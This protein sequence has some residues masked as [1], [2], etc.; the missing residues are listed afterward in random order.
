MK[1]S[2]SFISFFK[3][4]SHAI[5]MPT[6]FFFITNLFISGNWGIV[7]SGIWIFVATVTYHFIDGVDKDSKKVFFTTLGLEAALVL[8]FT[9][10]VLANTL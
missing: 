5:V 3:G 7:G 10:L 2:I 6:A 4:L 9:G 8:L 1:N